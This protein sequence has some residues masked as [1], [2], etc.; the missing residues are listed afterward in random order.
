MTPEEI[1]AKAV[2]DKAAADAA[3]AKAAT[4]AAA[5]AAAD[6]ANVIIGGEAFQLALAKTIKDAVATAAAPAPT[7][8]KSVSDIVFETLGHH[9]KKPEIKNILGASVAALYHAKNDLDKA[10]TIAKARWGD[11][12]EVQKTFE[13]MQVKALVSTAGSDGSEMVATTVANEVIEALRPAS[14]VRSSAPQIVENATGTLQIPRIST[15]AAISWVG[16]A[17]ASNATQQVL[18]TVTLTRK[19]GM[20]KVPITKELLMFSTPD[21]EQAVADDVVAGMASGTDSAYIRGAAAG[22]NPEGIRTQLAAGNNITSVGNDAADVET[23]ISALLQAVRGNNVALTPETGFFWMSSRSFTFLEKLRDAN[24]NLIYPE[25]RMETA[26]MHRY[27]VM[28]TN[29]IPDNLSVS[30]AS[31]TGDE[32]EIYFGRG[33]S[34]MIADARDLSLEVLEN[35]AYTNSGGTIE[36]GVDLDTVLV[37]AV[38][39]TDIAL[40]HTQAWAILNGCQYGTTSDV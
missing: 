23:D 6:A 26:R 8:N 15:G 12:N 13:A 34:M 24:G 27:R 4:E 39:L 29:N 5:K 28:I 1:A 32:S 18:D 16:E 14:I 10:A 35:V 25:L 2:A 38:L 37:K 22:N 11:G 17:S 9:Q 31:P 36:S 7:V 40:R 3:A 20:I 30:G 33:P 21:A 19:K